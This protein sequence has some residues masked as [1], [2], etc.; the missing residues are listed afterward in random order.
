MGPFFQHCVLLI[1]SFYNM[2]LCL[3][4]HTWDGWSCRVTKLA[5]PTPSEGAPTLTD[6]YS[7]R[8]PRKPPNRTA[9]TQ[10]RLSKASSLLLFGALCGAVSA[11]PFELKSELQQTQRLRR[12][13]SCL[14]NLDTNK[15]TPVDRVHLHHRIN[16]ANQ[17]FSNS[18]ADH[19]S[20]VVTG[21]V[22][23][24]A[25]HGASNCFHDCDPA[26]IRRL[27]KPIS[28]D[29]IAGGIDIHF[30][31]TAHFETLNL[32]GDVI[33]FQ[34]D[35]LLSDK[36][37]GLLISPQAFLS[38]NR[39]GES[40]GKLEDHFRIFHDRAEWHKDGAHLLTMGYDSSFL[41][42]I[43]L[44]RQGKAQPTL[45]A[46]T[47]VLHSSNKNLTAYQKIWM[48]WHVKLGHLGFAHV[49][50]LGLGGF[51]DKLALGL[52]RTTITQQPK[53]TACQFG[54]QV[55]IADGTTTT[56]KNPESEGAL[57]KG[58]MSVGSMTYSDQLISKVKGR[59][60][61]TAGREPEQ[62]RYSAS[63]VFYDGC[64]GNMHF[65]HQVTVN[66]TDT[67][68]A[69]DNY[70]R[71]A[72]T[73]G[74]VVQA[75]HTDNGIYK[76]QAFA[77][78]LQDN[79]QSI[80]FSGVG[81][82]WQNGVAE[83]AIGLAVSRA[84]TMMLHVSLHWPDVDDETLWP[85]ALSHAAY[86]HNHTPN[87]ASGIAPIEIFSRTNSDCSALRLAHPWGCPVYV[88][89]PRL[90]SAG[91]KIP[92]WQPR[93]R[94]GQYV[95]VSPVHADNIGMV[96]NLRTGRISPQYHL[97]YD[98]WFDTVYASEDT[99]PPDWDHLCIF[100]KF[101]TVF[102]DGIPPPTL[103]DE[104]LT[105]EEA[106]DN[107][108]KRLLHRL[109]HGRPVWQEVKT[110]ESREDFN[111]NPPTSEF[112]SAAT[113]YDRVPV[114]V[115]APRELTPKSL[116]REHAALDPIPLPAPAP[117]PAPAPIPAP[118]PASGVSPRRNP[119][120]QARDSAITRLDPNPRLKSYLGMSML[121]IVLSQTSGITPAS[122][123][124]LQEQIHGLDPLTGYQE[125]MHPAT[126][127]SQLA[128]KAKVSKD[129]DLPTL[130]ESLTGPY[131]EEFW[132]AMDSEVGS[133]ES[134]DTYDVVPRS[135][136]PAGTTVVPGTWVQRIKRLPDGKLSK[137]KSRWCC[138]GD[139]QDYDGIAYSPLVGFPTVRAG[140][141]LA[142]TQGWKSRQVDFTLAFCQSPQP[143]DNPLYMELPQYYK[144]VGFEGQDV[145]LKMNKS[146]YGQVDSPKLFYE[147]LCKGMHKLGF[148][149]SAADPCLFI[150]KEHQLMV[151]NYCDDQIWLSPDNDLIESYVT[152]LKDLGYDLTLEDDGDIFGFLG[153]EFKREGSTIKLTQEGLAKKVI[154]YTGME[155]ATSRT[156]PAAQEPLGSD[157]DGQPFAEEWSYPA[158]V[159]ML[160]YLSSNTRPDIQFAV[161]QAA[162]FSH[163]PRH[164]H[165]QAVK[166]IVRYLLDTSERGLEFVPKPDEGL[167]CWVDA[168]FCGLHGYEDEQDPTSVKS[169]TGFVLTLCGCPILW[170]SK[171]QDQICLSS[172]AAEYVAFSMAMRELLPMRALLQEIGTKLD[173]AFIKHSLVRSTVFEDNQGCLSLVNVPKMSPRNKY[174]ALKY[175]FFRS[176]IGKEKG[177]EAKYINTLEQR[178][179]ILTKGL[180][181]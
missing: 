26:S 172:T 132:K 156:T 38:K 138:R 53:C 166:R 24:G 65:E 63:T 110:K 76:S 20:V 84:R 67:I 54:K 27:S 87:P 117:V 162:R 12:L 14:G 72:L 103:A 104:W 70:E 164:S 59:L 6:T 71:M 73:H 124:L 41:P 148:E 31:G 180:P 114:S 126:T 93:S 2:F 36:L 100:Q 17:T 43:T 11:S 140:M 80:R 88:L 178:A 159:G 29:G 7:T 107:E 16:I 136:I 130:R 95:G 60:L 1:M 58:A 108:T 85:L 99:P 139:L 78:A 48:Q 79:Y 161:H 149:A 3:A 13:R 61:H 10:S 113:P 137:F 56:K 23:S 179:D 144:P 90:T 143:A 131:A 123:F 168:D 181:P 154:Q 102:E 37:P 112:P 55:R 25:S 152:Q 44:F 21:V 30:M 106:A 92:K 47:S 8:P 94:R 142:A 75:Y 81:A 33:P 171:L 115:P 46:L 22:D 163:S 129:P 127:Q 116:T 5:V 49:Q 51:L 155:K 145:V 146:I 133:L 42:R 119:R 158:A 18:L 66:A 19:S 64:S 121:A 62:D 28:L 32:K 120:R 173:L 52:N 176:H 45:K 77:K 96:R 135:S 98:D 40:I 15:L 9:P 105:P 151:L 50:K 86:L 160:L 174:L 141:I 83:A 111:Y 175:H 134:K 165:G 177:I 34:V 169:R 147:H 122:A 68:M 157:K 82:K 150:H 91:G 125:Y 39:S 170:S 89:E 101:E 57:L 109:R 74:V 4:G 128:L 118:V 167:D 35:L 69:K 153:V 97:V